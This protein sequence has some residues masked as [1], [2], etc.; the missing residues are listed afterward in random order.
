MCIYL[1][2]A[3]EDIQGNKWENIGMEIAQ[4]LALAESSWKVKVKKKRKEK[5]IYAL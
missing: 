2:H 4:G 3:R 5:V 1:D